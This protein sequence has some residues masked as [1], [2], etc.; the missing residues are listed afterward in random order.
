MKYVFGPV[1]SRRLGQ[2]LGVDPVPLKTCNWNCIYCQLGRSRPLVNE[3]RD[4]LPPDE[5]VSE[6]EQALRAHGPEGIDWITFLGS[7]EPLLHAHLGGMLRE[8]KAL[9]RLPVA[10]ITNGSLLYLPAVRDELSVADAV[11]PTVD[12]GTPELYHR[13]NRPHPEITYERLIEG[14][15]A[16]GQEYEGH[17]WLEVMLMRGVNDTEGALQDIAAELTRIR[18]REVH[19]NLPTRPPAEAWLEPA[20]PEELMRA[21]ARLEQVAP[22]RAVTPVT[23][24]VEL[25]ASDTLADAIL[26]VIT[27]HPLH[28]E[29]LEWM[30]V[31]WDAQQVHAA[32]AELEATGR[33]QVVTR[34]GRQFWTAAAS[35]FPEAR[36]GGNKT[37]AQRCRRGVEGSD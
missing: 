30:L 8:V 37:T 34:Y 28:Q 35:Y 33:A 1:P 20:D 2:S 19:I 25:T 14:L 21:I 10:V 3:R 22:V 26:A 6:V 13:I 9:T 4:Y 27:R 29:E 12:A 18:P 23:G 32:L 31:Y 24:T 17:L 15:I 11:L 16:F 5:I 7:G 36:A